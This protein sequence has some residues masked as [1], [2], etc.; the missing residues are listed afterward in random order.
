MPKNPVLRMRNDKSNHPLIHSSIATNHFHQLVQAALMTRMKSE[1]DL[2]RQPLPTIRSDPDL[3]T[4]TYNHVSHSI[5]GK[6]HVD[7][8]FHHSH[9]FHPSI[10]WPP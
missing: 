9:L 1:L 5:L 8:M 3:S 7:G 4:F 10:P 6:L 2:L